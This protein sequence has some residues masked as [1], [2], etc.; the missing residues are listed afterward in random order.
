MAVYEVLP[1]TDRV[2]EAIGKNLA[3]AELRQLA[4]KEGLITLR[5]AALRKAAEGITSIDEALRV[6]AG[7][8]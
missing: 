3:A 6:T 5:H 7:N 1:L 8:E 4:V 2:R